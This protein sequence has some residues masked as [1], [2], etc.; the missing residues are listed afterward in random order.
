[1]RGHTATCIVAALVGAL[2]ATTAQAQARSAPRGPAP[3][4]HI[5]VTVTPASVDQS[6][7]PAQLETWLASGT[8]AQPASGTAAWPALPGAARSDSAD[9]EWVPSDRQ[10]PTGPPAGWI[11]LGMAL[12]ALAVIGLRAVGRGRGG[13]AI[14]KFD[15][16]VFGDRHAGPAAPEPCDG[17]EEAYADG[18]VDG[19]ARRPP[20]QP[21]AVRQLTRVK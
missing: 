14:G 10:G 21:P 20:Q 8:A 2:I 4:I 16:V 6:A 19:F 11:V 1:M 7:R 5:S 13:I 12:V 15:N 3:I 18:W 9:S 17:R